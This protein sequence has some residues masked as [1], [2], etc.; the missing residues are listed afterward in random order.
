MDSSPYFLGFG[1]MFPV[2][3]LCGQLMRPPQ[4]LAWSLN[5]L[6]H[7]VSTYSDTSEGPEIAY[8]IFPRDVNASP[9]HD[10]ILRDA[11]IRALIPH[12]QVGSTLWLLTIAFQLAL[13]TLHM[14]NWLSLSL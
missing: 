10:H 9:L 7:E 14:L 4:D 1:W 5:E 12:P 2:R 11:R 13:P 8:P 6:H 3:T